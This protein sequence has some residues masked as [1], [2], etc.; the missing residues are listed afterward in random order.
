MKSSSAMN[1]PAIVIIGF[2]RPTSL[3]R[4]LNSLIK[5]KYDTLNIPLVVSVDFSKF[6]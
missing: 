3:L 2:N 5:A 4:L 6:N 1:P